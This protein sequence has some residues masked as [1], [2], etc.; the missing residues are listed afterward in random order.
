MQAITENRV[1]KYLASGPERYLIVC[2]S[3]KRLRFKRVSIPSN[4]PAAVGDGYDIKLFPASKSGKGG[5]FPD[6]SPGPKPANGVFKPWV[7]YYV[8]LIGAK[9]EKLN[10]LQFDLDKKEAVNR[11]A[12]ANELADLATALKVGG[13]TT[14]PSQLSW[15]LAGPYTFEWDPADAKPIGFGSF[16]IDLYFEQDLDYRMVVNCTVRILTTELGAGAGGSSSS[17]YLMTSSSG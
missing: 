16:V 6:P 9:L 1:K 13:Q 10:G 3:D 15:P 11:A 2:M 12:M 17:S 4:N 14:G 7:Q 8:D 5:P